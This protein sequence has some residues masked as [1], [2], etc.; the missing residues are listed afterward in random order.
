VIGEDDDQNDEL[1]AIEF[2]RI[3]GGKA[4]NTDVQW[5]DNLLDSIG[6]PKR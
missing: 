4:F 2:T 6:Q 5:F 1:R 3:A